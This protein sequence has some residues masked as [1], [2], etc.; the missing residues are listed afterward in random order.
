MD[1]TVLPSFDSGSDHRLLRAKVRLNHRTFKRD[2][3]R[4]PP[5]R[6]P[7]YNEAK[8][9]KA[10]D[11]YHWKRAENPTEDYEELVKG[12]TFCARASMENH[13]PTGERLNAK[14]KQLL[15]RRG[16]IKRDPTATH[17][18]K[19]TINKA[20]RIAMKESLREHRRNKLL[21]AATQ[22][23]SLKRCRRELADYT[24][25]TTCL[26]DKDG[27]PKTARTDIERIVTDFYTNL[28]RS[29]TVVSRC[30]SPTEERPL[31]IL[32]SEVRNA[33][34]SL[35]KGTAPGPD[36]ITADLLRVGGYTMNKLLADHFNCYLEAG[37]I[38]NQW[39]CSKTVLVL[40]KGDNEDIGNYR[41]IALLSIPY[42][43]F[44]KIMLNRLEATLDAYQPVE[45]AGFR[46][47]FCCMDH[48]HTVVQLIER[49][50][51]YTMPLVLT[52]IDYK[53]AFDS[54]ETNAV[55]DA[56][57]QAGVDSA[58]VNILEQCNVGTVT[59]IQLFDKKLRIPIEK[60]VRQGDTI[61]P[62]L[63]TSALQYAMSRLNW[64]EKGLPIDGKMLSNLR[65]AD[66]IVLISKNTKEMN[67]LINELN[68]VGKSIG[69]E[70]NMKKTQTMANQW[71]DNG[72]IQLDG[73]PLQKV[74]S[75]VYLGREINMK[76]DL[77]TEIARRRKAAWAA[78]DTI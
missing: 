51:E 71:S 44:T 48:I 14:A 77:T 41:P 28:Y 36:G 45:Q 50:R 66:G 60:G 55:L 78:M 40:K 9:Q 75:F 22:K 61:S 63:F 13:K 67:Q 58:Y 54:V 73:I 62:K 68:E 21:T 15:R 76:N 43:L 27:L 57:L 65:F 17:L 46:K 11:A 26:K 47:G 69:M 49:C 52:F 56:L 1:T 12:L 29:T 3:H 33:I 39:K 70:I 64:D 18:E 30:S 23:R 4:G 32:T 38:P 37:T 25:M 74:D 24:T 53:K 6:S 34:H 10:M 2:T 35:K 59:T 16:E 20:C 8:L 42:K 72:T 31:P 5:I 19:I 7:E